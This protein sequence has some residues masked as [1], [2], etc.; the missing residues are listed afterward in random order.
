MIGWVKV[1][2]VTG[3][4]IGVLMGGSCMEGVWVRK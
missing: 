2:R 4:W 3:G 1:Q